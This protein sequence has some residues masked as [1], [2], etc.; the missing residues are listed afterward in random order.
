MCAGLETHLFDWPDTEIFDATS[1]VSHKVGRAVVGDVTY[2]QHTAMSNVCMVYLVRRHLGTSQRL[3]KVTPIPHQR[4]RVAVPVVPA[5][6]PSISRCALCLG[7]RRH[8]SPA[9]ILRQCDRRVRVIC[10][11]RGAR[12][13]KTAERD[14]RRKLR[15]VRRSILPVKG[16][17]IETAMCAT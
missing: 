15:A 3:D 16:F 9:L 7:R 5:R 13:A 4:E 8:S 2:T 11:V 17:D 14:G 6:Q 12:A 1:G 10:G